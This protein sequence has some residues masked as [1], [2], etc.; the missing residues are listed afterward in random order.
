MVSTLAVFSDQR[1]KR[2][3]EFQFQHLR[4]TGVMEWATIFSGY[5]LTMGFAWQ[6]S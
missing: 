2:W 4:T 1:S 3:S 5:R 6:P